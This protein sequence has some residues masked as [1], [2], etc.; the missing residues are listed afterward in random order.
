MEVI[1]LTFGEKLKLL[2]KGKDISLRNLAAAA[3]ITP[4]Y[5]SDIENC[6]TN[7]LNK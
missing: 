1:V 6:K 5:L 7:G 4:A 3:N 2:R